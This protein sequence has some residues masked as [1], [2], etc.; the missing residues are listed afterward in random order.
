[1]RNDTSE[2]LSLNKRL[3]LTGA[4][5][6]LV[7]VLSL[8]NLGFIRL[9]AAASITILQIP[10]ILI[11]M[12]CSSEKWNG[13]NLVS[14]LFEG[15]FVG[16]MFGLMSLIKAATSP[17]G[18]L[19]PLFLNPLCSVLPRMLLGVVAWILWK[20]FAMFLPKT[21]A[22]GIVAFISTILHTVF[23]IGSLYLF[24]NGSAT[25]AMNGLG[26]AAI[27][28]A[29]IPQA[30]M[31]AAASTFFCVA[32]YVGLFIADRKGSKFSREMHEENIEDIEEAEE[33]TDSNE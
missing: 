25:Q 27:M 24:A 14:G 12:L 28:V 3:V 22:A 26:F 5:S 23:V 1:M 21:I 31:E 19:D 30:L 33:V 15:V 20:L 2:I 13:I 9:G 29:L 4:F 10:V 32:V 6:A 17:S 18:A 8:T 7:I 16:L 11:A